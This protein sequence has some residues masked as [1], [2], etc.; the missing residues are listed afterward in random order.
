MRTLNVTATRDAA[1]L[2][3]YVA[4]PDKVLA[5]GDPIAARLFEKYKKVPMPNLSL[6]ADDV[7]ALLSY[8]DQQSRATAAPVKGA[9]AAR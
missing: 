9:S 3:R 4:T 1:W 8:I 7:K 5:S 2:A 6:G